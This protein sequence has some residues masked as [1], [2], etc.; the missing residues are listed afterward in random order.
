M[1]QADRAGPVSESSP[2]S[3]FLCKNC[4]VFIFSATG[5]E[6]FPY[7]HSC[8][9]TGSKNVFDESASLSK[10]GGQSDIILPCMHFHFKSI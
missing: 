1:S 10:L 4:D 5:M 6:V 9:V 3:Y 2:Y 7:E 8:P